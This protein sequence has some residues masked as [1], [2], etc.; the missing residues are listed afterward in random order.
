MAFKIFDKISNFFEPKDEKVRIRD[1]VREVP[2][3]T[4]D[5][6]IDIFQGVMRG[7]DSLGRAVVGEG[8]RKTKK[9]E[10]KIEQSLFGKEEFSAE[11]EGAD[12]TKLIGIDPESRGGKILNP[13][14]GLSFS[15][16]DAVPGG[17]SRRV[18]IDSAENLIKS[19]RNVSDDAVSSISKTDDFNT[20]KKTLFQESGL[21]DSSLKAIG[22]KS[23]DLLKK[24]ASENDTGKIK[25]I[26]KDEQDKYINHLQKKV[27]SFKKTTDEAFNKRTSDLQKQKNQIAKLPVKSRIDATIKPREQVKTNVYDSL[28][29]RIDDISKATKSGVKIAKD[30]VFEMQ[31]QLVKAIKNDI[32]LQYRG[33]FITQ[34]RNANTPTKLQK[35]LTKVGKESKEISDVAQKAIQTG[36]KRQK[37]SFIQKMNSFSQLA[38]QDI[39]KTIGVNKPIRQMSDGE[40]DKYFN[41]LV[42]RV[43]NNRG[44]YAVDLKKTKKKLN[45]DD[46]ATAHLYVEDKGIKQTLKKTRKS[47]TKTADNFA[48]VLSERL[49]EISPEILTAVR[50]ME[51][52]IK[53][54]TS[55][56]LKT[57]EPLVIKLTKLRKDNFQVYKGVDLMLKNGEI[58]EALKHVDKDMADAINKVRPML[59]DI[60]KRAK[61]TGSDIGYL[62]GFFPRQIA[63]EKVD[64]FLDHV[65]KTPIS[66]PIRKAI[67]DRELKLGRSLDNKE[68]AAV[69]NTMI[70]GYKQSSISLANPKSFEK[71]MFD[72]L[73]PEL[74]QYYEDVVETLPKYIRSVNENIEARKLFGKVDKNLI[75]GDFKLDDT[76]GA[77]IAKLQDENKINSQ[78]ARELQEIMTARFNQGQ[79]DDWVGGMKNAGYLLTMGQPTNALTQIGDLGFSWYKA[80][81]TRTL[82]NVFKKKKITAQDLGITKMAKEFQDTSG[83]KFNI[84]KLVDQVFSLTGLSK[85]DFLGKNTLINATLD[86]S[87]AGIKRGN[88]KTLNE[89]QFIFGKR[90]DEVMDKMS[91][92]II[93]EDAKFYAFNILS[94]FQPITDLEVPAKYLTASNGKILYML[95]TWSI[96]ALNT[97][98]RDV[99]SKMTNA[100]N[101]GDYASALQNFVKLTTTLTL[102]GATANEIK[103]FVRGKDVP[104]KENVV[105][106]LIQISGI[107]SR[108]GL[109]K[110]AREGS[111]VGE[112]FPVPPQVSLIDNSLQDL[113]EAWITF[114][115]A[116]KDLEINNFRLTRNAP[117]GGDLYYWWL[118][119]GA[120][121]GEKSSTKDLG[122]KTRGGGSTSEVKIKER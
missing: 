10:G 91:R 80:G 78:Q 64:D 97:Y 33:R 20:I 16:V 85:M 36:K 3:A 108:Y 5:V 14:I 72:Y 74:N 15:L 122:I 13:I 23:D 2:G 50:K 86:S 31:D 29:K 113:H 42:K 81:L 52:N 1:V 11:T 41:E 106:A 66:G 121:R 101:V 69:I 12:L 27:D 19:L 117:L 22:T 67:A 79:M 61:E 111:I 70:R 57:L 84:G 58:D 119:R 28:I 55:K 47:I 38:T 87:I 105:T 37:I 100:D 96:K 53:Q 48:G 89:F 88:K 104:F 83:K 60:H 115:D 63:R 90:A 6:G 39:K 76:I 24:L 107:F 21:R 9:P 68:R 8:V 7:L 77:Y 56:D 46:Y 109:E 102:A 59:D 92:G 51:F 116:E 17:Q 54:H 40:V 103:D 4:K 71:R 75:D 44:R 35:A 114:S 120:T 62:D 18:A 65:N 43:N 93:D 25:S 98:R 112:A 45:I 110:G 32:P 34:I 95:Q 26:L 49:R 30:E 73:P 99:V 82:I 94:D 118:G